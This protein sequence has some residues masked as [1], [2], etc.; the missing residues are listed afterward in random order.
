MDELPSLLMPEGE[1]SGSEEASYWKGR[2]S[3]L[4]Y[5]IF[6]RPPLIHNN[7]NDYKNERL[8]D[9]I[10]ELGH[11]DV[12][13]L[14]EMF[15]FGSGRW[16]WL[17][18]EARKR[19]FHVYSP[20][21]PWSALLRLRLVDSGLAILT[22]FPILNSHFIVFSVGSD[23]DRFVAKGACAAV[24]DLTSSSR[25]MSH[26]SSP[27]SSS[28]RS[29]PDRDEDGEGE[30][31]GLP[32]RPFVPKDRASRVVV[33]TTHIQASYAKDPPESTNRR[34][35]M[36]QLHELRDFMIDMHAQYPRY[37]IMLCGDLNVNGRASKHDGT[38]SEDYESMVDILFK[39]M[40][41]EFGCESIDVLRHIHDGMHP[42][43]SGDIV[44]DE[45]ESGIF[46]PRETQLTHVKE[47]TKMQRLDYIFVLEFPRSTRLAIVSGRVEEFFIA[48]RPYTQL[49]DHYGV[50]G[51]FQ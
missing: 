7:S 6:E 14:Q 4:S 24:L 42:I 37:P 44:P 16:S 32:E 47:Q 11:F 10:T 34:V 20:P 15:W 12:I 21:T 9:F 2:F 18:D 36:Q 26:P 17:A 49:S 28:P 38:D 51:V 39:E 40:E 33:I 25:S 43:T 45:E 30:A 50:V 13:C 46:S 31:E 19:G 1:D 41:R 48:D 29:S 3:L 22:R 27:T 5:N 35:R 23:V 8:E